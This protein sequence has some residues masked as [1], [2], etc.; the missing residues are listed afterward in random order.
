MLRSRDHAEDAE[1][2][3]LRFIQSI[4]WNMLAVVLIIAV[5]LNNKINDLARKYYGKVAVLRAE[6][7]A[8]A[9]FMD[10]K[11]DQIRADVLREAH[12][13]GLSLR[14]E[15]LHELAIIDTK[16]TQVVHRHLRLNNYVANIAVKFNNIETN[17]SRY[18][19]N[20]VDNN[21]PSNQP[22]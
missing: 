19:A 22:T 3:V 5:V 18:L 8:Y 9:Q 6:H 1:T 2:P 14:A 17:F 13:N 16:I 11:F 12:I 7:T 4:D 20:L 21:A 10:A 15:L